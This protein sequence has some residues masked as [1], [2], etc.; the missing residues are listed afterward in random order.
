ML[1]K[2]V[3]YVRICPE[4]TGLA[5]TGVLSPMALF[6]DPSTHK[7][8][9]ESIEGYLS[10]TV[11][12]QDDAKRMLAIA[13]WQH[14]HRRSLPEARRSHLPKN[15][16]LIIGPTGTG[17]TLMLETLAQLL[18]VPMVTF[19]TSTVT[20]AGYVGAKAEQCVYNLIA[21]AGSLEKAEFGIIHLD[22]VDKIRRMRGLDGDVGGEAAQ[23]S[24]LKILEGMTLLVERM[25][26]E[27]KVE[28][29]PFS[30][31]NILFVA[32]GAF[33]D[34]YEKHSQA[35]R[36]SAIGFT[37]DYTKG[38]GPVLTEVTSEQL[39][40]FGMISEFTRRLPSIALMQPLAV[41]DLA[42]IIRL[43]THSPVEQYSQM[44]ATMGVET[45]WCSDF[46]E[47]VAR[48]AHAKHLGASG[49]AS[50]LEHS[51]RDLLFT[52]P[53]LVHR[54]G[55]KLK[56]TFTA[57]FLDDGKPHIDT[58]TATASGDVHT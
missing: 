57:E 58:G 42:N 46:I 28:K 22:E 6:V 54:H 1:A 52:L 48:R 2:H 40:A 25:N 36:S 14:M 13:A 16:V 43:S 12:G 37:A 4:C 33:P 11:V 41:A 50:V 55:G 56:L 15:N 27:S 20:K 38:S 7:Q 51:F 53:G 9:P 3:D 30:T 26:K 44:L 47:E 49:I 35:G 31:K 34:L 10:R 21:A 32:T 5:L 24:F 29:V 8:T 19:D 17:K 23:Q 18:D 45:E 39:T